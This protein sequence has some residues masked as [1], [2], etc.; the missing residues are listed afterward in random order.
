MAPIVS[1]RNAQQRALFLD[2]DGVVN[3]DLGYVHRPDQVEFLDGIFDLCRAARARGFLTVI[4]TNQAG[5]ARGLYSVQQFHSLMAW[6]GEQFA[7]NGAAIHAVYHCPHHPEH[8]LGRWRRQC[9]CRKPE[10]GMLLNAQEELGLD[11]SQSILIGDK[12]SDIEAARRAKV[13]TRILLA[14][15]PAAATHSDE[16]IVNSLRA[17]QALLFGI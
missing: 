4:V 2:R 16:A 1:L 15:S 8:G 3:A 6:I 7:Q 14:Q 17:A 10:P 12:L 9:D 13:G 11:L 5:I